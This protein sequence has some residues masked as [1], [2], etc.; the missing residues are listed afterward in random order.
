MFRSKRFLLLAASAVVALAAGAFSLTAAMGQGTGQVSSNVSV[1]MKAA[2]KDD[3]A[4]F[5]IT[6]ANKG[7]ADVQGLKIVG[8]L[9]V[10]TRLLDSWA[11]AEGENPAAVED[12]AVVWYH[13]ALAAGAGDGP[14]VFKVSRDA[15]KALESEAVVSWSAPDA[16]TA[17]SAAVE[18]GATK[19]TPPRR[20][21]G[22]G[23]CHDAA[24][25]YNLAAEAKERSEARGGEHPELPADTPLSTCLTCHAPG[26]GDRT[27]L[28][29]GA[30]LALRD[31]VHPAH[32]QSSHFIENYRGNCFTC[33]NVDG[34]GT[35]V[36]LWGQLD[37]NEKGVPNN[38]PITTIP[39]SEG[40]T[41]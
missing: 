38:P 9:P 26:K 7:T 19:A 10:G 12:G 16:G 8:E 40:A 22:P 37:E 18:A 15:T 1:A 31:I 20:G 34:N 4:T 27:G 6:V 2:N 23:G 14:F 35:F 11:G 13:D 25:K 32:M 24:S 39:P 28:G 33:H 30:P 3:T 36:L 17:I 41:S 5:T 21:C 29:A